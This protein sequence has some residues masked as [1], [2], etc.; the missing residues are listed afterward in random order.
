MPTVNLFGRRRGSAPAATPA[1]PP[2]PPPGSPPPLEPGRRP[3]GDSTD[4]TTVP[5]G[6]TISGGERGRND[7]ASREARR[8]S[9]LQSL[10]GLNAGA[11]VFGWLVTVGISVLLTALIAA[12]G[13]AIGLQQGSVADVS[14]S[15]TTLTVAGGVLLLLILL[16]A[17]YAGGYVAG[18]L[19]RFSGGLQGFG[20]WVLSAVVTAVLAVA[21]V[22]AGSQYNVLGQ[23]RLPSI[24]VKGQT[25]V[26][27]GAVALLLIAIGT[28]LAAVLGGIVGHR[29]HAKVDRALDAVRP[30]GAPL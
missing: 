17:Y 24:P 18:R 21:G 13:T 9:E 23:L 14:G 19:S 8:W 15:A 2:P 10:K 7:R 11:A 28:L 16:L 3:A 27:G 12:G 30:D 4:V 5:A 29:Y 6:D 20:V 26:N 22:V 1:A 25:L